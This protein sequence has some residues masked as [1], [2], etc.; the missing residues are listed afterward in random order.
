MK[1]S[2]QSSVKNLEFGMKTTKFYKKVHNLT[3]TT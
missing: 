1:D 2:V 3:R